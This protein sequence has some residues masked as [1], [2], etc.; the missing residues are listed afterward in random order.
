MSEQAPPYGD[1]NQPA[2]PSARIS[3]AELLAI[4]SIQM[5]G[6]TV[7]RASSAI[8]AI[9]PSTTRAAPG[10]RWRPRSRRSS[11]SD[12]DEPRRLLA[13][14]ERAL[15]LEKTSR[16]RFFV[17][18]GLALAGTMVP[19]WAL[20][21]PWGRIFINGGLRGVLSRDEMLDLT[22]GC[23]IPLGIRSGGALQISLQIGPAAAMLLLD[24]SPL[25]RAVHIH[26]FSVERKR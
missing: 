22:Q 26:S 23:T 7:A 25:Y 3:E 8:T 14:P 13:D 11:R 1:G 21:K 20:P 2:A 9:P 6:P 19:G 12:S 4:E 15:W 17:L 16:R 10:P 24:G 5:G 18:S